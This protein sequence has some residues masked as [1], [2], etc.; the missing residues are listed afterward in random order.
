MRMVSSPNQSQCYVRLPLADLDD[1]QWQLQDLLG[2]ARYD[3]KGD[4]LQARGL[5]LDMAPW[6]TSVFSLKCQCRGGASNEVGV[7][8]SG[9]LEPGNLRWSHTEGWRYGLY[10][11]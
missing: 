1:G 9:L 10:G 7:V 8:G 5:Y 3:R 11:L 6:Q 4:D 2:D